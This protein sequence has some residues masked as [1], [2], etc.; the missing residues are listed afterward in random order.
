MTP[1]DESAEAELLL[2]GDRPEWGSDKSIRRAFVA[3]QFRVLALIG[4]DLHDFVW[5][6]QDATPEQRLAAAE[7]GTDYWGNRWFLIP[8]T[9][10]GGWERAIE[11]Y[12]TPTREEKLRRKVE[13][14]IGR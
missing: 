3:S 5:S 8:N 13:A 4:D 9:C 10:N 14:L 6:G 12:Q 7:T 11:G 1:D 2:K